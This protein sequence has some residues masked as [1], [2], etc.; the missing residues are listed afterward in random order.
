M[1][2]KPV[3]SL[4]R[5]ASISHTCALSRDPDQAPRHARVSRLAFSRPSVINQSLIN[6]SLYKDNRCWSRIRL[7]RSGTR[8][9]S[10][11]G[12]PRDGSGMI[13]PGDEPFHAPGAPNQMLFP[14][15]DEPVDWDSTTND[16]FVETLLMGTLPS[17]SQLG[18][19]L[20]VYPDISATYNIDGCLGT[21]DNQD[22][23]EVGAGGGLG[24][25]CPS[26]H[27]DDQTK[28][29]LGDGSRHGSNDKLVAEEDGSPRGS[30]KSQQTLVG[31]SHEVRLQSL[32]LKAQ[33]SN[34]PHSPRPVRKR[35]LPR[36]LADPNM[37][38]TLPSVTALRYAG[39]VAARQRA[40][41][42]ATCH[43]HTLHQTVSVD[44]V[45]S[46]PASTMGNSA[47]S[48]NNP[49]AGRKMWSATEK[50]RR[51]DARPEM[52]VS[53]KQHCGARVLTTRIDSKA[54]PSFADL[55][56]CGVMVPGTHTF[57]VGQAPVVA[58][59][60]EDGTIQYQGMRFRAVS[61]FALT[62]LR[63]RNPAR[64]SCDG[65]KEMSWNGEK[66]DKLR[67][68]VAECLPLTDSPEPT[69]RDSG[70]PL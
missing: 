54:R 6:I 47:Q 26:G 52:V 20:A 43:S 8:L 59:V 15:F 51:Q 45:S 70:M 11:E 40:Y 68:R 33:N 37:T 65:W 35:S 12:I 14:S 55:V 16:A 3:A 18:L 34:V 27:E 1:G 66:L 60:C 38:T 46:G 39:A 62:V 69:L 31:M 9:H 25:P 2:R 61:K 58:E 32:G 63:G 28:R 53:S 57:F 30:S 56:G 64:Q 21:Q 42:S 48:Q 29:I 36:R 13:A 7:E 22:G 50:K 24:L 5:V 10:S 17:G 23:R 44:Q 4:T 67:A 49:D 19:S 41:N